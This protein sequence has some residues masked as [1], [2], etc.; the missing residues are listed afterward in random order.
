MNRIGTLRWGGRVA[1]CALAGLLMAGSAGCGSDGKSVVSPRGACL[2][3]PPEPIPVG[4]LPELV[5]TITGIVF[6]PNGVYASADSWFRLPLSLVST[7]YAFFFNLEPVG[8]GVEV[9]LMEVT[10]LDAAD[11]KFDSA[12][13]LA[14]YVHTD[15]DG[16]YEIESRVADEIDRCRLLLSVGNPRF[17]DQTRS[18]V[19]SNNVNI[20]PASEAVVRLVLRRIN[21][22]NL[23]LCDFS[24]EGLR[25]LVREAGEAAVIVEGN[26]VQEAND[27]AY[28]LVSH[29]CDF[30]YAMEAVTQISFD[31]PIRRT[32]RGNCVPPLGFE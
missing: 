21:Q 24:P 19:Y 23:Q 16:I 22:T 18:F 6:A 20:D 27:D 2:A 28:A 7:A 15:A 26:S 14:Q 12:Q 3:Q 4:C 17:G 11:G 32:D 31:P 1:V 13:P 25:R 30:L 5:G 10:D 29:D 8:I 9:S